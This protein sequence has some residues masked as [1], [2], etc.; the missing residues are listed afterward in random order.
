M[1]NSTTFSKSL[2]APASELDYHFLLS[3]D[4]GFLSNEDYCE[5]LKQLSQVRTI[6]TS[7][8]RKVDID[9]LRAKR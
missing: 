8:L 1:R 2:T 9:C 7:L 3:R 4:L 6:L 5:H